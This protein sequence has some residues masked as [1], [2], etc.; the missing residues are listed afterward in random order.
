[1]KKILIPTDFSEQADNAIKFAT[2]L[3][4]LIGAELI[5][6]HVVEYPASSSFNVTG[7]VNISTE[8]DL[9]TAEMIKKAKQKLKDEVEKY[10]DGITIHTNVEVGNPYKSISKTLS[11]HDADLVVMGTKGTSDLEEIFIGSNTEKMV[12]FAHVPV[13]TIKSE[14]SVNEIKDIVFATN[15]HERQLPVAEK[16]KQFQ[17][18]VGA[19]L[20]V[21][22]VNTPGGFETTRELNARLKKFV[23]KAGFSNYTMN[24]YNDVD[25]EDGITFFAEDIDAD[26]IAMATHGRTG[27]NHLLSGSIAEDIVNHAKRPVWTLSLK[28]RKGE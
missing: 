10:G 12:R 22:V 13:I 19:K 24:I 7:E 14:R 11:K 8:A 23:E 4:K 28:K 3:A 2:E 6:Q 20:H 26:M 18:L 16:I 5:F 21:V 15:L 25:E 17:E 27:L 1:M 9:F